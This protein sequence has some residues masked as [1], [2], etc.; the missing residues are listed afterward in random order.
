MTTKLCV[1]LTASD[2]D[3]MIGEIDAA[4][5]AGAEAIELRLD[6]LASWDEAELKRLMR[7]ASDFPGEVIA[8]CRIA[9]EGGQWDG[10]E[11]ERI[12]LLEHAGLNGADCIDVEHEAWK[13]SANIR[14]KIGLV[15]DVNSDSVRPRRQLILS[16]HDFLGTP[17]DL[18]GMLAALRDEPAHVVKLATKAE[19]I[20]DAVRML[21][22]V[23]TSAAD[24]PTIGLAMGE[25][26]VISRVLAKKI[27]AH[28]TFASL[29]K[30]KE[31]AP[32]QVTIDEMR[33]LYR[34]NELNEQTALYGVIGCPVAHS[35]SPAIL[36][37]AFAAIGH[38][39]V[40]L[41]FRVEPAYEDFKAFIDACLARPWLGLRGCSVTIP[42][43]SNL[44][45][46]VEERDGVIEPLAAR[47][48]VAN[49][50]TIQPGRNTDGSD[51]A[52]SAHNTDYQGALQALQ[53]GMGISRKELAGRRVLVLGAGGAS[54]AIV[55]GLTDARRN[56]VI[57]NRTHA[58]AEALAAD[59]NAA[60]LPWDQRMAHDAEIIVN[61]TS[62]GMWPESDASPMTTEGFRDKPAVFDTVYNPIET[63]LLREAKQAG[64]VT[65]DGVAMFVNQASAQF[66]LWTHRPAPAD[67]MREAVIQRLRK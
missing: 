65:I 21:D 35:M 51:A 46:Y 25:A 13:V 54:R 18:D 53:D 59:F 24:R 33:Q 44:L 4:T 40:Y 39:A 32:G 55:A 11:S 3:G 17:K 26:G 8:T 31:S 66:R 57:S 48:G 5:R 37:P 42:H 38:N 15:C 28:V 6:Y 41:P 43:K 16:R 22:L 14:Q 50:L 12:S 64:C 36:N 58:R 34:W 52:V 19:S 10:D 1:P 62:I 60:I 45:R 27:G 30:G 7:K 67:L 61:C 47:I 9:A 23:R 20:V 49:T 29:D 2:V 63:R 56:V